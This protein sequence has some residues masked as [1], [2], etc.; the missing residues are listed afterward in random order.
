MSVIELLQI[1]AVL[2][3]G[4]IIQSSAGFGFG[5]FAV[6]LLL[7][8]K[9]PLP[10]AVMMVIFG[11]ALQKV[12]GISFLRDSINWRD[13]RPFILTGLLALP[14]GIYLMFQISSLQQD[15]I[16]QVIGSLILLLLLLRRRGLIRRKPIQALRWGYIAAFLSGLLNGLANIGGPPLVLWV[17]SHDWPNRKMRGSIFA[18]SVIF[19]PFQIGL[20]VLVFERSILSALL[21]GILLSPLVWLGSW[22][23]LKIGE[24]FSRRQLEMW[25]QIILILVAVSA[26]THPFF[27]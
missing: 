3:C 13:L 18:I 22:L 14:I 25:M 2:A 11:S 9:I 10:Q 6:P 27:G 17:L 24:R 12:S 26:F 15:Y 5:L 20:M 21:I 4:G 7:L 23:G 16:K 1:G 19:A 8:L